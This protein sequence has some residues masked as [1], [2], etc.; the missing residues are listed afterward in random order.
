MTQYGF[1]L[2]DIQ[3]LV[4]NPYQPFVQPEPR[5]LRG[6]Q[7][8]GIQSL[9]ESLVSG[10]KRPVIMGATGMGKT[11]V[12]AAIVRMALQKGNRVCFC[13]PAISLIDQTVGAFEQDGVPSIEI[14]V[15]QA[16]HARTNRECPVQIASIQTLANRPFPECEMVI[17]DE[18][19]RRS[20]VIEKWMG[21]EPK[22]I[23]VGLSAT[24][25]AKGMGKVWDDLIVVATTADLIDQ[26]YL[27]PFRVFASAHPDLSAVKTVAG[28]YHEGQLAEAMNKAAL[29]ADIVQT[30]TQLGEN[31]P[32]LCFCVD[33]AHAKHVQEQFLQ[34][35]ISCGYIDAYT[36]MPDREI[37]KSKLDSGSYKV[38]VNVGCLT[39][40]VD[41]DIRC[42]IFARPTKS[43]MLFVQV[44]GRGLRTA[45]GKDCCI[46]LDHS[47][48][49][50]RLG[51]V[52]DINYDTLNMGKPDEK[53][54]KNPPLPKECPECGYLRPPKVGACPNCGHK[55][56]P[57]QSLVDYEKGQLTE[58]TDGRRSKGKKGEAPKNHVWVKDRWK[59]MKTIYGELSEYAA[60]NNYKIG[61]IS[62]KFK[63]LCGVWPNYWQ[64]SPRVTVSMEMRSWLR[65][66]Q[67]AWAKSKNNPTIQRSAA[68]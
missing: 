17:V 2:D 56:P 3:S 18:C 44:I 14:G 32:T 16:Q 67:I 31:R 13:V 57:P 21:A 26:G 7:E 43:E 30:W 25:W 65:S 45:E 62:H 47:D 48:N 61:W 27:S 51:F 63:E 59:D 28:D 40:G 68:K 50:S 11:A 64:D 52:T 42:I 66:R 24:P 4:E 5:Q 12:S 58:I 41:W 9:R 37:V 8:R 38:V 23:F 39:T 49:H 22:K 34:S 10:H 53:A 35:G 19:H 54:K 1:S 29:V 46:I 20:A 55:S 15:I 6:Y 33:R 36:K 60:E